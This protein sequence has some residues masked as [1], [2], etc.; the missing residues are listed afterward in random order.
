MGPNIYTKS[1]WASAP[2]TQHTYHHPSPNT[3]HPTPTTQHLTYKHINHIRVGL[4]PTYTYHNFT[5][6][7][8]EYITT[9]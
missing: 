1:E 9:L 2:L 3:H 6:P 7:S 5:P 8:G 4:C